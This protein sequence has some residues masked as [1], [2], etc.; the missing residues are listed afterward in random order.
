MG[1]LDQ[2]MGAQGGAQQPAQDQPRQANREEQAHFD[3]VVKQAM[4]FITQ[5]EN[6][7]GLVEMAEQAGPG[8]A[9]A[10]Y[11]KR[12]LDSIYMAAQESGA[13]VSPNTMNASAEAVAKVIANML[14]KS[15][16]EVDPASVVQEAMS[17]MEGM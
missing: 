5:E 14:A 17:L 4:Q 6:I 12:T 16:V 13:Q 15:G 2:A 9:V 10:T 7:R 8:Q 1:L 11:V 3:M